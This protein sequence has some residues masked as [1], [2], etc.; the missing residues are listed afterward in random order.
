[1]QK[2]FKQSKVLI[3]E[4]VPHH[5]KYVSS[6]SVEDFWATLKPHF[7]YLY[8]PDLNKFYKG[9][10]N[11]VKQLTLMFNNNK[12]YDNIVFLKTSIF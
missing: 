8:V 7:N 12:S 11:I 4:F 6:V 5:L 10:N 1:M 3:T 2:I 9:S